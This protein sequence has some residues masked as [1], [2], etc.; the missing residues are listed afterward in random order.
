M[1]SRFESTF[2]AR[3]VPASERAF[4]VSVTFSRGHLLSDSFTA[5]RSDIKHV[6][7][8]QEL[9]LEVRISMRDFLFAVASVVIDGDTIEPQKGDKITEGDETFQIQPPD[10]D[11]PAVELQPG[12]LEWLVHTKR[13]E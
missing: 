11:T 12:G 5:R 13:I 2:N 6:A 10:D 9:G 3:V 4:G 7:M 8:G 1:P